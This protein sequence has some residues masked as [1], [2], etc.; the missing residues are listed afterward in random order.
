MIIDCD[1]HENVPQA[2]LL[3]YLDE[4]YRSEVAKF[5]PRVLRSGIRFE[6]GGIRKDAK[7]DDGRVGGV[8][9]GFTIED[10]LDRWPIR[11]GLL[12]HNSGNISGIPD[13]DYAAAL[14]RATNDACLDF[15][16]PTDER[17]RMT[18]CVPLQNPQAAAE[19]IDRLAG[20]PN[21]VAVGI[22]ATAHR[23]PLGH[24][25]Y[26][27]IYE[28]ASRHNLPLHL[29]PSTTS[30][31]ASVATLPS[32]LAANYLQSH[33][34]LPLFYQSDLISLLYEGVFERFPELKVML[35]E[36]GVSWL[37]P[38]LWRLDKEFKNL[39]HEAPRLKRLPSAYAR[40][41]IRLTTQPIEEPAKVDH[42]VQLFNIIDAD[43]TVMYASDY[44]HYDYD[45]PTVLPKKLGE[46][47]LRR[48]FHD[49]ACAWLNLPAP[50]AEG[51]A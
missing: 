43:T 42:L 9:P 39:R 4:P 15:W 28:A 46:T 17:W 38:L 19:E 40:D 31:I 3:K 14:C 36:G 7:A 49:N 18:V 5:G 11:F 16:I 2:M 21:V 10:H 41:H 50:V 20:H 27:P 1:I 47:T 30:V 6:D 13:P 35:V 8:D 12:S 25:Y 22:F 45:P 51:V 37:G 29:H 33:A 26:Y 24:R 32:G 48:I 23:I 34:A 44:P